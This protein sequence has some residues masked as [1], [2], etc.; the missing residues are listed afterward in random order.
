MD[1]REGL[2]SITIEPAAGGVNVYGYGEFPESSVNQGM[3][4]RVFLDAFDPPEAAQAG[5]RGLS[6]ARGGVPWRQ[7]RNQLPRAGSIRRTPESDGTRTEEPRG[8]RWCLNPTGIIADPVG[9]GIMA[10]LPDM[11]FPKAGNAL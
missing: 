10:K 4:C 2:G 9:V 7:S 3:T 5:T 11:M 8:C 1:I 6:S